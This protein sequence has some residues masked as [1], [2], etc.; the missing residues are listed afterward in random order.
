[1]IGTRTRI[2]VAALLAMSQVIACNGSSPEAVLENGVATSVSVSLVS[3]SIAVGE[4]TNAIATVRT[5]SGRELPDVVVKWISDAPAVATVDSTSGLIRAIG[6][7]TSVIRAVLGPLSGS[8][9]LTVTGQ[10]GTGSPGLLRGSVADASG[11]AV[12]GG[13]VEV[14]SPTGA[15]IATAA[16]ATNGSFSVDSLEPGTYN[17]RLQPALAYSMGLSE[18]GSRSVTVSAAQGAVV[19][20][21]VQPAIWSDDFQSYTTSTLVAGCNTATGAIPSGAFFAGAKHD[22]GCSNI[23]QIS[24]DMTGGP[25]GSRAARYD[26]SAKPPT[27]PLTNYCANETTIALQP[28]ISSP[29]VFDTLWV[30]FTSKESANFAPGA[31]SCAATVGI[32]YKFFL[33]DNGPYN[34]G[35]ANGRFGVYLRGLSGTVLPAFAYADMSDRVGDYATSTFPALGNTFFGA[36][37]TWVVQIYNMGTT[38]ATYK[39]Y[40]DGALLMTVNGAYYPG[41]T[42]GGQGQTLLLQLGANIN[43]GP[44]QAQTRWFREV[45]V[46]TT[47]PS[48]L[49][50]AQ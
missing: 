6:P 22:M 31:Q 20:F 30:R 45:G 10:V 28:R 32:S 1:M 18:P 26:W 36:Y 46:Y 37:H 29:P 2:V 8:A 40:V 49:P 5:A 11:K 13:V 33:M 41:A 9:S 23:S 47:R 35:G 21:V 16:V 34:S 38:S 44:E 19:S 39:T 4:S 15:R 27:Q 25:K 14:L 7:G 17:V 24:M 50:L 12:G 3:L 48:L 42:I 43:N